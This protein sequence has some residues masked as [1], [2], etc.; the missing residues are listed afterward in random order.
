MLG[1]SFQKRG[2]WKASNCQ[3]DMPDSFV[4][5]IDSYSESCEE[6]TS[7]KMEYHDILR[8]PF[9]RG[10]TTI[11]LVG[12]LGVEVQKIASARSQSYCMLFI[13]VA[14]AKEEIMPIKTT[15]TW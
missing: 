13:F 15:N 3:F 1:Q 12:G 9:V 14:L 5:R 8:I 11:S 2:D 10:L 6:R 4:F 7:C